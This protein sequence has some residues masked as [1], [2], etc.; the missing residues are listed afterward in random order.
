MDL[1]SPLPTR[2][3]PD[4]AINLASARRFNECSVMSPVMRRANVLAEN[5]GHVCGHWHRNGSEGC[6]FP[7]SR[8]IAAAARLPRPR[9]LACTHAGQN[10]I[11]SVHRHHRPRCRRFVACEPITENADVKWRTK[12]SAKNALRS[13][14]VI[15]FTYHPEDTRRNKVSI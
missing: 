7:C 10:S 12:R 8:V 11:S 1:E 13:L 4:L 6:N 9:S 3:F 14:H 15:N 5:R 2:A